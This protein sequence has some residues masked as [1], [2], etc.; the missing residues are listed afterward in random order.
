M[1]HPRVP[2][3]SLA[4]FVALAML[5]IPR[6]AAACACPSSGP[7]CE[8]VWQAD[9]VFD[10]TVTAVA[11]VDGTRE[12]AGRA[13]TVAEKRVRLTVTQAWR[14]GARATVDVVTSASAAD[15]GVDFTPGRRYLVFAQRRA[16]D[17]QLFV[18]VCS[19]TTPFDGRGEIADYWR[20]LASPS[21][22]G[23][24][25]GSVRQV[26]RSANATRIRTLDPSLLFTVRLSGAGTDVE[27]P[28]VAGRFELTG[29]APGRYRIDLIVPR[30]VVARVPSRRFDLID[31]H[32]CAQQDFSVAPQRR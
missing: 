24:V 10:G 32:A 1:P 2:A 16:T 8:V 23:R 12:V 13:V 14:G 19:L 22:G 3:P 29:V 31:P 15:C 30:G 9:T 6:M 26:Q 27:V 18:S 5:L 4:L 28:V 7:A 20:S 21:A 25:F 17:R 11:P